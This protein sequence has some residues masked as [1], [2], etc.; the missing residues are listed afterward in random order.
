MVC[1]RTQHADGGAEP[2]RLLSGQMRQ[3]C[4]QVQASLFEEDGVA[5]AVGVIT[6]H[7][8]LACAPRCGTALLQ[9]RLHKDSQPTAA[10]GLPDQPCA[11]RSQVHLHQQYHAGTICMSS[12]PSFNKLIQLCLPLPLPSP[13]CINACG[14][15]KLAWCSFNAVCCTNMA[16]A[17]LCLHPVTEP[18][19]LPASAAHEA[20]RRC[21]LSIKRVRS[22]KHCRQCCRCPM[23][24]KRLLHQKW[25]PSSSTMRSWGSKPPTYS[26]AFRLMTEM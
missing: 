13:T 11:S 10:H 24:G 25:K 12:W 20:G 2:Q 1:S 6:Q 26:M 3:A 15:T 18:C 23:A 16:E 5:T 22:V 4:Q 19:C 17:R 7:L 9:Q 8:K 21:R 14:L